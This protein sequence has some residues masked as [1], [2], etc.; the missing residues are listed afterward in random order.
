MAKDYLLEKLKELLFEEQ[1][2]KTKELLKR[3]DKVEQGLNVRQELESKIA[4]I[5]EDNTHY[6]QQNF[7]I[8]FGKTVTKTMKRQIEESKDEVVEALYPIIGRMIKKYVIKEFELLSERVDRQMEQVFSWDNWIIRVK[9]WFGGPSLAHVMASRFVEPAL[10]EIF[11]IEQLSGLLLG[12]YSKESAFDQDMMAG[13]M[14]AIKSFAQ[15]ALSKE[16]Q[17]LEIVEYETYKLI[18]KDFSSFY[19]V[20]AVSGP[21]N[22]HFKN[23]LDDTI[24]AFVNRIINTPTMKQGLV[25]LDKQVIVGNLETYFSQINDS[26]Q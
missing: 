3:V 18:I 12:S 23:K 11:V 10:E 17:Q 16:T 24:L 6:L 22:P 20:A 7:N 1:D 25:S 8:L 5:L 19:V 15:D 13:M 14:T 9:S 4:P 21:L 26:E 2:A